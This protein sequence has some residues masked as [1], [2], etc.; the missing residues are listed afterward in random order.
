[1]AVLGG[2][3]RPYH[4]STYSSELMVDCDLVKLTIDTGLQLLC[5]D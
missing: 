2:K 3:Q 4:L 1:M 5:V